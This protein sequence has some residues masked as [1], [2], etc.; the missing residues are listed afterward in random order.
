MVWLQLKGEQL[1]GSAYYF[2]GC[3]AL[4]FSSVVHFNQATRQLST[5]VKATVSSIRPKPTKARPTAVWTGDPQVPALLPPNLL[6][7]KKKIKKIRKISAVNWIRL[8][9]GNPRPDQEKKKTARRRRKKNYSKMP[10]FAGVRKRKDRCLISFSVWAAGRRGVDFCACVC[11]SCLHSVKV[12]VFVP[13]NIFDS[14]FSQT[15]ESVINISRLPKQKQTIKLMSHKKKRQKYGSNLCCSV[16]IL[17]SGR[18]QVIPRSCVYL[19][20]HTFV[21]SAEERLL[22]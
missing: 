22:P 9:Q 15:E 21:C 14:Y 12:F 16:F 3:K 2:N 17:V 13:K 5:W 11:V 19:Y 7:E 18:S 8:W 4:M 20:K 6:C 1:S 10:S